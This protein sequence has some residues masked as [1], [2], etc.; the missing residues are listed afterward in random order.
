[1]EHSDCTNNFIIV[2]LK[3]RASKKCRFFPM[4]FFSYWWELWL[5]IDCTQVIRNKETLGRNLYWRSRRVFLN[6]QVLFIG[7]SYMWSTLSSQRALNLYKFM[8]E[9]FPSYDIDPEENLTGLPLAYLLLCI[10]QLGFSYVG[11]TYM[12][13]LMIFIASLFCKE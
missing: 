1:M 9:P 3:H 2:S 11:I 4:V 12:E 5:F 13:K 8:F 7:M 10:C 6:Y